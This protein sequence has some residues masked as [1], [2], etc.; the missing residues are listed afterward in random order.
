M[1]EAL[2]VIKEL[3]NI[4]PRMII[5][6]LGIST[7]YWPPARRAHASESLRLGENHGI[8]YGYSLGKP[9]GMMELFHYSNC[10]RSELTWQL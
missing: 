5:K 9:H 1:D 8:Y 2:G 6:R 7:T 3:G 4:F 10:E